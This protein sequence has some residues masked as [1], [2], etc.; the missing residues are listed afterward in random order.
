MKVLVI[1]GSGL[2]GSQVIAHLT[3]VGHEAV[4]ASPRSGVDTITGEGLAEA[5]AGVQTVVDVSNSPD[6][7]DEPVLRFFTTSTKNLLAAERAAGVQHHVA[8]SI[9][10]ADRA[11][12]S[13]YMRAKVA[14][15]KLIEESGSPYSIVRATQFFEFVAGLADSSTDGNTV[16]LP[17]GAFQP[18]AAKDVATAVTGATISDPTNGFTNIAGPE[19]LGMDEFIRRALA[20]SGDPRQVVGDPAAQYF[21]TA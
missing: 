18:I 2:I 15:E 5:V 6:W 11:Q 19:K 12:E 1:G 13:G 16:P 10:G 21:G 8:L 20:A 3:E 9:V 17:E 14:Q 4:S 7:E